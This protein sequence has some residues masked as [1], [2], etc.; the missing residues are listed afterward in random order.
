MRELQQLFWHR[1]RAAGVGAKPNVDEQNV[2]K[3]ASEI[4]RGRESY[5]SAAISAV[6][7]QTSN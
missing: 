2:H 3:R 7:C 4:V 5:A 1:T 6:C